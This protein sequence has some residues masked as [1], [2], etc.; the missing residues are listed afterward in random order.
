MGLQTVTIIRAAGPQRRKQASELDRFKTTGAFHL[1]K[2]PRGNHCLLNHPHSRALS[3]STTKSHHEIQSSSSNRD[4][5]STRA[6]V[7]STRPFSLCPLCHLR[8]CTTSTP[9]Y[10]SVSVCHWNGHCVCLPMFLHARFVILATLVTVLDPKKPVDY[11]W[12]IF[13]A[14]Y[15]YTW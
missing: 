8:P 10:L 14:L 4:S 6:M 13:I 9:G 11:T 5:Q 3:Q 15:V 2:V 7:F 12:Y 1:K